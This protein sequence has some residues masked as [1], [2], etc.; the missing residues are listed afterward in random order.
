MTSVAE[1][2]FGK[3][4]VDYGRYRLG[5][6][7]RLYERLAAYDLGRSGQ[8]LL[9]VGTGTGVFGRGFALRGCAVTGLDPSSA[10]IDEARRLD[11]DAGLSTRY[12]IGTAEETTLADASFD[13]V[14]A[15]QC[16]HW[17]RRATAAAELRRVLLPGGALVIAHYDWLPLPGSAVALTEQ[18]I[19]QHNPHWRGA[20]GRGIY[21]DWPLDLTI[22]G[23][24]D[25]ET[26][27][28]DQPAIYSHD[29]WRGRVRA[30]AG[31]AASLTPAQVAA[32]DAELRTLLAERFARD[33]IATPHRVFA[34]VARAP[35]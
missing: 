27:T 22:A 7:D 35:K 1:I 15:G 8:R 16:W 13:V 32:F 2:D 20:G 17:F 4:A 11:R 29:A 34:L 33:P 18:L 31:I 9:D 25:L 28:F 30:S 10:L 26:F 6:P 12:V 14:T 19:L 5:F 23:F 21:P 3:T 24:Q